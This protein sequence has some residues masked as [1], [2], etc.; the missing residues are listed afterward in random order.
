MAL[1]ACALLFG[2]SLY[3]G[4][5]VLQKADG[6]DRSSV[7]SSSASDLI[8]ARDGDLLQW[9]VDNQ[10]GS[11]SSDAHGSTTNVDSTATLAPTTTMTLSLEEW[12]AGLHHSTS[13]SPPAP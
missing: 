11:S 7:D 9:Q 5:R 4:A 8:L 3:L 1:A 2:L 10:Y 12:A 13:A 6:D